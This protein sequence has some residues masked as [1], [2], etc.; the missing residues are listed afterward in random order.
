MPLTLDERG[1]LPPGIH[2]ATAKEVDD[3]FGLTAKSD[4]RM[5]LFAK[6][7]ELLAAVKRPDWSCQVMIDGSFVMKSVDDPND[8]D[9]LLVMPSGPPLLNHWIE[10]AEFHSGIGCGKL[11]THLHLLLVAGLFPRGHLTIQFLDR[12]NSPI[13]TLPAQHAQFDLRHV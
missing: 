6:F 3:V 11:P 10:S 8:I 5:R 2:D 4:R 12:F 13:Q 9:I 7:K 1:L